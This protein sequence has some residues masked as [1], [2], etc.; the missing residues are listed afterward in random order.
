MGEITDIGGGKEG[1]S[2]A[3]TDNEMQRPQANVTSFDADEIELRALVRD[4]KRAL[5]ERKEVPADIAS[6]VLQVVEALEARAI[7]GDTAVQLQ[8]EV[9]QK[10]TKERRQRSIDVTVL[11][12]KVKSL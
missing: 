1:A 12:N 6:R 8:Q 7:L 2:A 9:V 5:A 3:S 4:A 11:E 10:A